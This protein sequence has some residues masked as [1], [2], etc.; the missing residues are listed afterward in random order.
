MHLRRKML[1]QAGTYLAPS[2]GQG[3]ISWPEFCPFYYLT[4]MGLIGWTAVS[5]YVRPSQSGA[6][7]CVTQKKW[8]YANYLLKHIADAD[9]ERVGFR[10]RKSRASVG[11]NHRVR[12]GLVVIRRQCLFIADF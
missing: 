7:V 2:I 11:I 6:F 1:R 12:D 9:E 10:C 8:D 3:R 4:F 5:L